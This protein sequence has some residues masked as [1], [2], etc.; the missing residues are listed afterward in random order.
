M[1]WLLI[2]SYAEEAWLLSPRHRRADGATVWM[3]SAKPVD[4]LAPFGSDGL[5]QCRRIDRQLSQALA[6]C[7]K[8]SPE[9]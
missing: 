6:G 8:D 5:L 9:L 2:K 1:S 4:P 7:R 3:F